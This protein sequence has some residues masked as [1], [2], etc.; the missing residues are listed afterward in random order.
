MKCKHHL[1]TIIAFSILLAAAACS[2]AAA[3]PAPSPTP[4]PAPTLPPCDST[5]TLTVGQLQR[6]YLLHIPPGLDGL[7]PVPLVFVFHGLTGSAE[8]IQTMSGFNEISDQF[9]FVVVYP[10]G[11]ERSWNGSGCCGEGVNQ[12]IDDLSFVRQM[13]ADL[14]TIVSVDPK[15]IYSTGFS[16][17]AIFSYRLACEMSDTFAAVAPISGWLLTEPCQPQQPVSVMHVHGSNDDYAGA[18]N[19]IM[20]KGHLTDVVFPAVEQGLAAWAQ[21]DGCGASPQVEEQLQG[22]VTHT[23]YAGCQAGS[24]VELYTFKN[25][26]H[27]WPSPYAFPAFSSPGIWDFF[28]AHPKP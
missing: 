26:G 21:L 11:F 13:L 18:L 12:F 22:M 28:K 2:P 14:G 25:G 23:A 8:T 10:N 17:G 27:T 24:A 20:I 9:G 5:R 19:R 7:Q 15:R 16:N 4:S 1:H 6:T 3:Q